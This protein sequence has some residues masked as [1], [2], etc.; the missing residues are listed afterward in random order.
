MNNKCY[1][2]FMA[3]MEPLIE[4]L[5]KCE[6]DAKALHTSSGQLKHICPKCGARSPDPAT[7][8]HHMIDAHPLTDRRLPPPMPKTGKPNI[9]VRVLEDMVRDY[10]LSHISTYYEGKLQVMDKG[11]VFIQFMVTEFP[12]QTEVFYR[13]WAQLFKEGKEYSA[14]GNPS[15]SDRLNKIYSS[16]KYWRPSK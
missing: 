3:D 2:K 16:S 8:A 14:C 15:I 6:E 11:P 5:F 13:E 10:D 4:A 12:N 7:L 9:G 1:A